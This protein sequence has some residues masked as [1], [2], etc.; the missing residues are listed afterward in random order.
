MKEV[1]EQVR[2]EEEEEGEDVK[3]QNE[4][5]RMT[6]EQEKKERINSEERRRRRR[7]K[8]LTAA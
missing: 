3:C 5:L 7:G 2:T 8:Q 1:G 6:N 4:G